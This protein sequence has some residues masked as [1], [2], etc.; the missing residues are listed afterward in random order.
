MLCAGRLGAPVV[1]TLTREQA[2]LRIELAPLDRQETGDFLRQAVA[3]SGCPPFTDAA[4]RAIAA[5]TSG[6]VRDV[7]RLSRLALLAQMAE[8]ATEVT[9]EIVTMVAGELARPHTRPLLDSRSSL[10]TLA[11]EL[12]TANALTR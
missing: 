6:I 7:V 2:E 4:Q 11:E 12:V 10:P 8:D 1:D 9:D 5:R 3:L